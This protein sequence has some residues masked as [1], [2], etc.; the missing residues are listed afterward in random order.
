[1]VYGMKST[2]WCKNVYIILNM[3]FPVTYTST[4][5]I[6]K[7]KKIYSECFEN[8]NGEMTL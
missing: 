5:I 6:T 1:M 8:K 2:F 4:L 7:E 3:D